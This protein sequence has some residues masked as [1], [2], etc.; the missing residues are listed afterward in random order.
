M[1]KTVKELTQKK[2]DDTIV[3]ARVSTLGRLA[4][5]GIVNWTVDSSG[6]SHYSLNNEK[7][8]F[9]GLRGI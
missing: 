1:S 3:A 5:M 8:A 7:A 4:E 2:K 9:L 6:M